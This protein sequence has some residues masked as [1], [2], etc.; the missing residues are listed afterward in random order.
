MLSPS[1]LITSPAR[2]SW[3]FCL[4]RDAWGLCLHCA[5]ERSAVRRQTA[6]K[7]KDSFSRA[8]TLE[9]SQRQLFP[10][11]VSQA[12]W[13]DLSLSVPSTLPLADFW[14]YQKGAWKGPPK[15]CREEETC[16]TKPLL[17]FTLSEAP[18][19]SDNW[20]SGFPAATDDALLSRAPQTDQGRWLFSTH[21]FNPW[22]E[23]LCVM[24]GCKSK[25]CTVTTACGF[26][27]KGRGH[28]NYWLCHQSMMKVPLARRASRSNMR[29]IQLKSP[30]YNLVQGRAVNL[31]E[32]ENRIFIHQFLLYVI[33]SSVPADGKEADSHDQIQSPW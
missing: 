32:R 12:V 27:L 3:G 15:W 10:S 13:L 20:A 30:C 22:W 11:R 18:S 4:I 33:T 14:K 1:L 8:H 5:D 2:A 7:Q 9:Q 17:L 23:G 28:S 29:L 24:E 25:K 26:V 6:R 19:R 31:F 21:R 16:L